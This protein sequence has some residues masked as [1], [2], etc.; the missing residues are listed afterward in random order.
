MSLQAPTDLM[1]QLHH[2]LLHSALK[3]KGGGGGVC[4]LGAVPGKGQACIQA[5]LRTLAA[6]AAAQ[7]AVR[8]TYRQQR[9]MLQALLSPALA[10]GRLGQRRA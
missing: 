8:A 7:T 9:E 6:S 4:N 2:R 5:A 10:L 1:S 3:L